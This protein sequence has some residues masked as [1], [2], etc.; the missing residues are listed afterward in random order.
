[1]ALLHLENISAQLKAN[2]EKIVQLHATKLNALQMAYDIAFIIDNISGKLRNIQQ[3]IDE[4][5][6]EFPNVT[7]TSLSNKNDILVALQQKD[8]EDFISDITGD[9][10]VIS[11]SNNY[12]KMSHISNIN[13]VALYISEYLWNVLFAINEILE[14]IIFATYIELLSPL[15]EYVQILDDI[16]VED[17][18]IMR[19]Q[20]CC[21]RIE[22][23]VAYIEGHI[24]G[25]DPY[26]AKTQVN[27]FRKSFEEIK[28]STWQ[29]FNRIKSY[30]YN[31]EMV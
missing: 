19:F 2:E 8:K 16:T 18:D 9:I 14:Q 12:C 6:D 11:K 24:E 3:H 21:D 26:N 17:K 13:C 4:I 20:R 29:S 27:D 22:E 25:E 15:N 7:H 1:M 30:I 28:T 31:M 5:R 10:C 23:S